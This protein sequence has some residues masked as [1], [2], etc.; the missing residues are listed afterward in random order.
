MLWT[1]ATDKSTSQDESAKGANSLGVVLSHNPPGHRRGFDFESGELSAQHDCP[2]LLA[3]PQQPA[4][5]CEWQSVGVA[6]P[7]QQL[8]AMDCWNGSSMIASSAKVFEAC[9]T[10]QLMILPSRSNC[11][12][13]IGHLSTI[14]TAP[15]RMI[16]E[17]ALAL[18]C[19]R[20]SPAAGSRQDEFCA[21]KQFAYDGAAFVRISSGGRAILHTRE[22]SGVT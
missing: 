9:G 3:P 17:I 11:N 19:I 6:L 5:R 22:E 4:S 18:V 21:K 15:R 2:R 13:A 8:A 1:L 12:A 16:N 7:W 10:F 14:S 20:V